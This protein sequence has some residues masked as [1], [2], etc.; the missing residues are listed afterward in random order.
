MEGDTENLE[1]DLNSTLEATDGI[2]PVNY[3]VENSA[4]FSGNL[5]IPMDYHPPCALPGPSSS[6]S[7]QESN[8]VALEIGSRFVLLDGPADGH[9]RTAVELDQQKLFDAVM[10]DAP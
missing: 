4:N 6:T 9:E 7:S 1:A 3:F 2:A 5:P 10:V 8:S